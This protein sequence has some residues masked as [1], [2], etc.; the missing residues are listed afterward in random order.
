MRI[1]IHDW[2][3]SSCILCVMLRN[4]T[5][6]GEWIG[7]EEGRNRNESSR[8]FNI[9]FR[10]FCT[11]LLSGP[12]VSWFMIFTFTLP[13]LLSLTVFLSLSPSFSRLI[14]SNHLHL[15]ETCLSHWTSSSSSGGNR[16]LLIFHVLSRSQKV[17]YSFGHY[18]A[19]DTEHEKNYQTDSNRNFL[20]P[21]SLLW[22]SF[23]PGERCSPSTVTFL[24]L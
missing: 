9:W 24:Q 10:S 13:S 8:N 20:V 7:R 18:T 16:R 14:S 21:H 22:V 5:R 12:K 11:K 17:I 1:C 15:L 2:D 6:K 19:L 23:Q 3:H 4:E